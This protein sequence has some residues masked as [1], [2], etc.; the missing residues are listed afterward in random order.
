ME[1]T[2]SFFE[3]NM[4]QANAYKTITP[5]MSDFLDGYQRGLRRGYHGDN[6]GTDVEHEKWLDLINDSTRQQL[7][8]GYRAGFEGAEISKLVQKH[9]LQNFSISGHELIERTVKPHST[10]A[11]I[12]VPKVWIGCRVAIVRLDEGQ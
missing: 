10:S 2:K 3:Q 4:K 8:Q 7:G 5:K 9:N 1:I 11:H 12:G 6:F